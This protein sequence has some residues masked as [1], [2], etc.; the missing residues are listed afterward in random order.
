MSSVTAYACESETYGDDSACR[1]DDKDGRV[2]EVLECTLDGIGVQGATFL[3]LMKEDQCCN[4]DSAR[5][6]ALYF[7][8]I[9]QCCYQCS[10]YG[11]SSASR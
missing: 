4:L 8:E 7:V 1:E 6:E 3:G 9:D 5:E 10:V 11:F 2:K